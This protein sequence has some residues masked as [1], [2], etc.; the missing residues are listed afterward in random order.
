MLNNN[1]KVKIMN[2]KWLNK[3]TSY[4]I[5]TIIIKMKSYV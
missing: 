2:L 5:I 3:C 1:I 4:E